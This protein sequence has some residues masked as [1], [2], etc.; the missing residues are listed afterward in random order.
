MKQYILILF[1]V[2]LTSCEQN[3]DPT[4][5][6]SFQ[7][8]N[9]EIKNQR[10]ADETFKKFVNSLNTNNENE[11]IEC[12][13]VS[14]ELEAKVIKAYFTNL[15]ARNKLNE[16]FV[17]RFGSNYEKLFHDAVIKQSGQAINLKFYGFS[18]NNLKLVDDG[19]YYAFCLP[20]LHEQQT[21]FVV[22]YD[23]AVANNIFEQKYNLVR[24]KWVNRNF[25][26]DV[27]ATQLI[28]S[29]NSGT[30]FIDK[31]IMPKLHSLPKEATMEEVKTIFVN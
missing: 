28:K 31:N 22:Q 6:W 13:R 10:T 27:H 12:F 2:L 15:Q 23:G 1:M 20:S 29:L 18:L 5:K 19:S 17:N 4:D 16:W 14:N 9:N 25:T 26:G 7:R 11:Y 24:I 21:Q 8:Y 30:E 3:S